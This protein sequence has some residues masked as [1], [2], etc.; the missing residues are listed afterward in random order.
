MNSFQKIQKVSAAKQREFVDKAKAT[1]VM[2]QS[3]AV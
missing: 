1:T 3:Q 2:L